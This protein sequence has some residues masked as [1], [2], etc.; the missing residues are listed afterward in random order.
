M[1]RAILS[2]AVSIMAASFTYAAEDGPWFDMQNCEMC[3]P[4]MEVPGL[5]DNMTWEHYKISAGLVSISTVKPEFVDSYKKAQMAMMETAGKLMKGEPVKLCN[6]CKG[7]GEILGAGAKQDVIE[8]GN[9]FI[10][11]TTSDNPE[12]VKKI[13][14]WGDRTNKEMSAMEQ[15]G[16]SGRH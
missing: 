6:M 14:A 8:S 12:T 15:G 2:V 11:V 9:T 7:W 4:L 5:M 10:A 1:K 3:K 16:H 13:H